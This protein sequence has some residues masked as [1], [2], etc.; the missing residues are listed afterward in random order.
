MRIGDLIAAGP[1]LSVEL[2]PPRT[3]DGRAALRRTIGE[4]DVLD[5]SFASVTSGAGGGNAEVRALT[6]DLVVELCATEPYP[7]MPHLTCMGYERH[8]LEELVADYAAHGVRNILALAGDPPADGGEPRGDFRFASELVELVASTGEFSIGVAAFPEVH[9]RSTDRS[10]DRRRLAAKLSAADFGITQ[11]FYDA[12]DYFTM[13][14]ELAAIGCTTPVLP[15]IMPMLNPTSIR[16]FAAMNHARFPEDLAARVDEA[17]SADDR[18]AIAVEAAV[19]LCAQLLER[20]V[21]GLHLYCLNRSEAV[22]A[23]VEA[24]GLRPIPG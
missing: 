5:L 18:L 22:I 21:P 13:V 4:F 17:S 1:T 14:D 8:E 9:P 2:F 24:L 3:E 12:D 19:S 23:I 10:E 16:R 6:R 15:G 20:G 11:F 7:T